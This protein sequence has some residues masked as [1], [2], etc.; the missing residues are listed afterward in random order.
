[1]SLF[2]ELLQEF[3]DPFYIVTRKTLGHS[4]SLFSKIA[5]LAYSKETVSGRLLKAE[6]VNP[7]QIILKP[8]EKIEKKIQI[9]GGFGSKLLKIRFTTL[10]QTVL[11]ED[12][13]VT[14]K[15]FSGLAID[16]DKE[17]NLLDIYTFF[18]PS[19]LTSKLEQ[20]YAGNLGSPTGAAIFSPF[21]PN[22]DRYTLEMNIIKK[23]EKKGTT[24][25]SMKFNLANRV[26]NR[27]KSSPEF[28]DLYGPYE[29]TANQ[30]FIFA[31]QLEYDPSVYNGDYVIS[32]T[33]YRENIALLKSE[34]DVRL[35]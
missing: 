19:E 35:E 16:E 4:D 8:G 6:I 28:S 10:G 23:S 31:Q 24:I 1:M 34:L 13:A 27:L 20:Y 11:E 7:E 22:Q 3:G 21:T 17:K 33:I 32:T 18:V 30:T 12:V 29:L 25:M 15:E 9:K 5:N 26:K 14:P 2:P